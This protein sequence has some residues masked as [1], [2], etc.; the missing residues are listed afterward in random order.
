MRT[1][2]DAGDIAR[3][4]RLGLPRD[5]VGDLA[6]RD[7]VPDQVERRDFDNCLGG[8]E[9]PD[10]RAR[11]AFGKQTLDEL[12]GEVGQLIDADRTLDDRRRSP[13]RDQ[14]PR[15]SSGSSAS[16]GRLLTPSSA[17]FTSSSAR[18]MS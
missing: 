8:G 15:R 17:V 6:H 9:A 10:R 18:S 14:R 12:V 13:G 11:H 4:I 16:A 7:V 2:A 1:R 5:G 3:R